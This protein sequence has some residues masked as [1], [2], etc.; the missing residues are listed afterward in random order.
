MSLQRA[1][2]LAARRVPQPDGAVHPTPRRARAGRPASAARGSRRNLHL[3]PACATACRSPRP[4]GGSCRHTTRQASAGR[5]SSVSGARLA[6]VTLSPSNRA[7]QLAARRVP[8]ADR[9]VI[10]PGGERGPAVQR[11]RREGCDG[12]FMSLQ[13]AQQLAARRVPQADRASSTR[14]RARAGRPASAARGLRRNVHVPPACATARR[15]PRPTSGSAVT[16]PGGERGPAVQRQRR[17]ACDGTFMSLQ[18]A[19]QLAA[20]RVPHA[21]RAVIRPGGE[22][23]PAVEHEGDDPLANVWPTICRLAPVDTAER[24][25]NSASESTQVTP[26]RKSVFAL[27]DSDLA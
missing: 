9:A 11:Q 2:Q 22:R 1:Q 16:G 4:T 18:R 23:G 7:Q 26:V 10:R 6:T 13:R 15:S 19:Q 12:T 8:Q 25:F 20:R 24:R 27:G 5:P 3:P 21:D 14:R 17:E